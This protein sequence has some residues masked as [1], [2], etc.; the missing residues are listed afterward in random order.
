MTKKDQKELIEAQ[1]FSTALLLLYQLHHIPKF[2]ITSELAFI[3]DKEN[4]I[5]FLI[6]FGGQTIKIPELDEVINNLK[7]LSLYQYY[8]VEGKSWSTAL[9]MAG[10]D[11]TEG[12]SA[13]RRLTTFRKQLE[14]YKNDGS[15]Y[16]L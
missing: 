12:R 9:E 16:Y 7:T 3:L 15:L 6:Y 8:T 11:R 10:F 13:E 1:A 5:N 2:S 4:L 14:T